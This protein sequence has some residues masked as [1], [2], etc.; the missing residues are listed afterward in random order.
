MAVISASILDADFSRL[1]AEVERVRDAG[2]D[3]FSLDVMDG[4]FV[5]RITFGE[6]VVAQIRNWVDVPLEVHLMVAEPEKWIQRMCDAGADLILFHLE[7]TDDPMRIV[8][9]VRSERRSVG[10]ALRAETPI[11]DLSDELLQA[12]DVVNLVSVPI[13]FGGGRSAPDT[14][15]R[16][17]LLRE[18]A[19]AVARQLA[20][21][22]DGG[23][24]A[25]NAPRY[26]EAGA[27]MLTVG[28]GIYHAP[29]ETQAVKLL[30]AGTVGP[31]DAAARRRLAP[32]LG[33]PS[34]TPV[35]D[36]A[37]RARLESLRVAQDVSTR[38][39][40]PLNSSR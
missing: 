16:L 21:E 38:V 18:R 30:R 32:F 31:A 28:T 19:D 24:K 22:V 9:H 11:D 27:D 34:A 10:V 20:I 33:L 40:D 26:V 39:W 3:A 23:V 29:D 6:Y 15:T 4:H 8:E 12:L 25:D 35:D 13:G 7:A 36:E 17:A 2:I 14:F 37:R 1:R 5:P